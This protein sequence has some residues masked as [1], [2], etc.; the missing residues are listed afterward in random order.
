MNHEVPGAW[1]GSCFACDSQDRRFRPFERHS[2]DRRTDGPVAPESVSRAS[3]RPTL[4]FFAVLSSLSG[5]QEPG[6]HPDRASWTVLRGHFRRRRPFGA[7]KAPLL[8]EKAR[9][10]WV[11]FRSDPL[12]GG[13][14]RSRAQPTYLLRGVSHPEPWRVESV[15][16]RDLDHAM[17]SAWLPTCSWT[18]PRFACILNVYPRRV[19]CGR[20]SRN[21]ATVWD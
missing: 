14:G 20:Q 21:G 3:R 8:T 18:Q 13:S 12:V 10:H 16:S 19:R 1:G 5:V 7:P 6:Q 17:I 2:P 15:R 4:R 11:L 9:S